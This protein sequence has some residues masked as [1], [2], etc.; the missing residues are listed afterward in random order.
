MIVL[1]SSGEN[2]EA[3][4]IAFTTFKNFFF[5]HTFHIFLAAFLSWKACITIL[6]NLLLLNARCIFI[7]NFTSFS[8]NLDMNYAFF[9]TFTNFFL[10]QALHII[11]AAFLNFTASFTVFLN[12]L[13]LNAF[14]IFTILSISF[15]E[16]YCINLAFKTTFLNFLSFQIF[17]ILL[18]A[19]LY[20][21]AY[22]T[23]YLNRLTLN[24]LWIF[25]T[26]SIS[27]GENLATK[28]AFSINLLNFFL[29]H[30]LTIFLAAYLW[31]T[32]SLTT[33]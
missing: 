6:L 15:S 32:A 5:Y 10:Y 20:A 31:I 29:L 23:T 16:N 8:E 25:I 2:L 7:I 27:F 9:T 26:F 30:D 19:F 22:F 1:M 21:I 12:L 18:A 4:L 13:I 33:F 24:F 28:L 11:L 14:W 3:K 17:H